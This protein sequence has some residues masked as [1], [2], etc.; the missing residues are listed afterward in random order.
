MCVMNHECRLLSCHL[1]V[2]TRVKLKTPT[3]SVTFG[4]LALAPELCPKTKNRVRT[5][6]KR[7]AAMTDFMFFFRKRL[8][9]KE[10]RDEWTCAV[11][12]ARQGFNMAAP[13]WT[14][15]IG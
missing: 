5:A 14:M 6:P 1:S 15:L 13:T 11:S 2:M 8:N 4:P 12:P 3:L 7:V 10:S 9:M